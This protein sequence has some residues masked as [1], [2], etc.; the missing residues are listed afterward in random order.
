MNKWILGKFKIV[1]RTGYKWENISWATGKLR[2]GTKFIGNS[3]HECSKTQT[4]KMQSHW[5]L[6]LPVERNRKEICDRMWAQNDYWKIVIRK[7]NEDYGR[8]LEKKSIR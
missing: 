2:M 4:E 1:R 7:S 8:V 5:S 6:N 3:D